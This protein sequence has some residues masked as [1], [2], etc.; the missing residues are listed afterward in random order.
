MK[1]LCVQKKNVCI[2][3]LLILI[4]NPRFGKIFILFLFFFRNENDCCCWKKITLSLWVRGKSQNIGFVS[5]LTHTLYHGEEEVESLGGSFLELFFCILLRRF[6]HNNLNK[7]AV[8]LQ[9][10]KRSIFNK[11]LDEFQTLKN[12]F[13]YL[14]RNL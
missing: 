12:F 10:D 5:I 7:I 13:Y 2:Y 8:K 9:Y 6:S 3:Q 14:W 1:F 11:I 4:Y